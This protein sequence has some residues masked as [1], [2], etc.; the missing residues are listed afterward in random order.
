MRHQ[1]H[2]ASTVVLVMEGEIVDLTE[3]CSGTDDVLAVDEKVGTQYLDK[4][5][6]I[7]GTTARCDLR[8]KLGR[9]A[10]PGSLLQDRDDLGRLFSFVS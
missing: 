9:H 8:V 6:Y 7:L 3:V 4:S 5:R 1:E 10:F 2:V